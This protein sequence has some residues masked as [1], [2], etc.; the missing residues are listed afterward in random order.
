MTTWPCKCGQQ[1]ASAEK[2][3]PEDPRVLSHPR[4]VVRN[5]GV[6]FPTPTWM[7]SHR[8]FYIFTLLLERKR[9]SLSFYQCEGLGR[10]WTEDVC[11]HQTRSGDQWVNSPWWFS[12]GR[13]ACGWPE[14]VFALVSLLFWEVY[15]EV[16]F[17]RII[18]VSGDH[19]RRPA[20]SSGT[21]HPSY[22]EEWVQTWRRQRRTVP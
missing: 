15:W 7:S 20:S 21:P 13:L 1:E 14:T 18:Q 4:A 19:Q 17:H 2:E 11:Y 3:S 16:S 9:C 12:S 8:D 5:P 10:I 6:H 22:L